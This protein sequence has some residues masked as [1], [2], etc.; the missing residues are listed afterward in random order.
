MKIIRLTE[1]DLTRIVKAV[2]NEQLFSNT[3]LMPYT[4]QFSN[5]KSQQTPKETPNINPKNLKVGDGGQYNP[6]EVADVKILQQK[7]M[8]LGF[9]KI[10]NATGYFGDTTQ[11]ALDAYTSSVSGGVKSGGKVSGTSGGK[12]TTT[13]AAESGGTAGTSGTLPFKNR[14]E[15]N[16]F[17]NWLNDNFPDA[18]KSLDL[19]RDGSHTNPTIKKAF[20]TIP[21]GWTTTTYGMYYLR[22]K[23]KLQTTSGGKVTTTN[24]GFIIIFAFPTYKPSLEPKGTDIFSDL[25]RKMTKLASGTEATK[26]PAFGHGG[27]VIIDNTG[28]SVL[29]EFGRYDNS[30]EY[31]GFGKVLSVNLGKIAKI[32]DGK[33]MNAQEVADKAKSKTQGEGPNQPLEGVVFKLP[34]PAAATSYA[35]VK[36]REYDLTDMST[37][38]G[39]ANCGTFAIQAAAAGGVKMPVLTVPAPRFLIPTLRPFSSEFVEA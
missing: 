9:L 4:Y 17:R 1:S 28:N 19:D 39:D 2:M 26:T 13:K 16:A 25:W 24:H 37:L 23:G 10:K 5:K 34:D 35:S 15:G 20:N 21:K 27:C 38:D 7:L 18:A 30:K 6:D 3:P 12:V 32:Q 11:A 36:K 8:A 33:L 29:Y 14:E 31:E 22:N